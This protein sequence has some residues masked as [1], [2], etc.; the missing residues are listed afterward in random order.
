LGLRSVGS[1]GQHSKSTKNLLDKRLCGHLSQLDRSLLDAQYG[2][3]HFLPDPFTC[4]GFCETTGFMDGSH[5]QLHARFLW[6]GR[7]GI[8]R[9]PLRFNRSSLHHR[10]RHPL[11]DSHLLHLFGAWRIGLTPMA[12]QNKFSQ[13][14]SIR[15]HASRLN[16]GSP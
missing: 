15:T 13:K 11:E 9:I 14:N 1:I 5:H 4:R 10:S 12:R 3:P 2:T 6:S 8:A 16:F 7:N